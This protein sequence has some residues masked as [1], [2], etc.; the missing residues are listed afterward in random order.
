VGA[1]CQS[2]EYAYP[3]VL[4]TGPGGLWFA[5]DAACSSE[6]DLPSFLECLRGVLDARVDGL[7]SV[8]KPRTALLLDN[9]GLGEG[10]PD[11][12]RPP[13]V[14][15]LITAT[16]PGSGVLVPPGTIAVSAGSGI[17][18]TGDAVTLGCSG[19]DNNGR[20]T[21][22]VGTGPAS[23]VLVVREPYGASAMAVF[24][25]FLAPQSLP[26]TI[27]LKDGSCQDLVSGTIEVS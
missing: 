6:V 26:Y 20:L 23:K 10:F 16:A 27:E 18:F 4:S 13:L 15:Q 12:F 1:L 5:N 14:D 11:L 3:D 19:S 21:V 24:G 8:L 25:P 7:V 2:T 17:R 9:A 22:H